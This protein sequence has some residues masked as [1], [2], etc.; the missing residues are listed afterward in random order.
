MSVFSHHKARSMVAEQF[1][2]KLALK[3]RLNAAK[4]SFKKADRR[5]LR[6]GNRLDFKAQSVV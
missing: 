6:E 1:C 4:K 2:H 5:S 3:K